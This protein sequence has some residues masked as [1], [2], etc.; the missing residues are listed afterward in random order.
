MK[1]S[2]Q[3]LIIAIAIFGCKSDGKNTKKSPYHD[4]IHNPATADLDNLDTVN[5]A[6]I[7]MIDNVFHFGE[8]NEG[9][10]LTHIFKFQNVG[11][12]DLFILDTRSVCG[13]TVADIPKEAIEPGRYGE[14]TVRFD[15]H[16][17][18][19]GQE[20][21]LTIFTNTIPNKHYVTLRGHVYPKK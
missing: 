20:K 6:K 11:K 2:I 10:T 9:D 4:L 8:L 1:F 21:K 7:R 15:T 16:R 14:I 18:T 17:K 3:I 12:R 13:C 19:E 5:I